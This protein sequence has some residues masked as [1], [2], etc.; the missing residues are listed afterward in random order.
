MCLAVAAFAIGM[1]CAAGATC[2]LS[3]IQLEGPVEGTRKLGTWWPDQG[4]P[5]FVMTNDLNLNPQHSVLSCADAECDVQ[6]LDALDIAALGA[7]AP[8]A[9]ADPVTAQPSIVAAH[10]TGLVLY[11]CND[12]SC[13]TRQIIALPNTQGVVLHSNVVRFGANDWAVA[14]IDAPTE[15]GHL[16]LLHCQNADCSASATRIIFNQ[17][18]HAMHQIRDVHL[19]RAND[20][21][22]QVASLD[23]ALTA[24]PVIG[25]RMSYCQTA[26]CVTPMHRM[27]AL[28]PPTPDLDH[29]ALALRPD[30]RPLV[31]IPRRDDPVLLDC[32]DRLCFSSH[33]L[34]PLPSDTNDWYAGL[35]LDSENRP[36]IGHIRGNEAGFL[37]CLDSQCDSSVS[38]RIPLSL[39]SPL[40]ATLSQNTHG[41]LV[42]SHIDREEGVP[43]ATRCVSTVLFATDFEADD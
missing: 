23:V 13:T 19:A 33:P 18:D 9:F 10:P 26:E 1:T 4:A 37:Q 31:L 34:R 35:V 41:D 5:A 25:V 32:G 29:L 39:S 2:Q 15:Q 11:R 27:F 20:G 17:F 43:H 8:A 3:D 40:A 21:G 24:N 42:L 16:R 30:G 28:G 36:I 22:I 7:S 6:N 12:V 38:N 14:Y